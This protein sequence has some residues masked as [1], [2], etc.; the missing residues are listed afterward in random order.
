MALALDGNGVSFVPLNIEM[1]SGFLRL[2][3]T[4][5]LMVAWYQAY[6][7]VMCRRHMCG[8]QCSSG[9][10]MCTFSSGTF[11]NKNG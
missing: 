11:T 6:K 5:V 9:T 1:R 8:Q 4:I 10:R 7:H 3:D 2:D